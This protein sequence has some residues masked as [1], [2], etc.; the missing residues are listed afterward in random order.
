M[1]RCQF[2]LLD[3]DVSYTEMLIIVLRAV[4]AQVALDFE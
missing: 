1:S 4:D 3:I 2:Y